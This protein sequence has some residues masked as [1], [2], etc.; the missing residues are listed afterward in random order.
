MHQAHTLG[1]IPARYGSTRF[2]GKPLVNIGGK[3]MIRRVYEQARKATALS[4]VWVATDDA[5]IFEHVQKFGGQVLLTKNNHRSGTERC[6]EAFRLLPAQ[7]FS[8]V[9]NIQ[10]DE[11]F[12]HPEQ[13]NE[14][15]SCFHQKQANIATLVK[16][17]E[18]AA[19]LWDVHTP[20]VIFSKKN[21]ILYFSRQTIPYIHTSSSSAWLQHHT[22]YKHIGL[23][24]Y[25]PSILQEIVTL[26]PTPLEQAEKLE[27][28]RWLEH[29]YTIDMARTTYNSISVDVPADLEKLATFF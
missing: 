19:E 8:C 15:I 11:P 7:S 5:R 9:V 18:N 28:L 14:L 1:I 13:I 26:S 22:F 12:I 27:Q 3:S 4:D 25:H 23:Y 24:A 20:K 16:K 21:K 29:G 2:P 17:I 6:A 10:G